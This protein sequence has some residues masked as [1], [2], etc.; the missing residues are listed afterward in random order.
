MSAPVAIITGA[1]DGIDAGLVAGYRGVGYAVVGVAPSYPPAD[2]DE[3][4]YVAIAGDI[5][6]VHTARR[7]V[8]EVRDGSGGSTR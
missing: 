6:D 2:S 4:D 5:A 1:S 3:S 8:D 7:A